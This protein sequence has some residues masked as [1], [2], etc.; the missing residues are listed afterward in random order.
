MTNRID[1]VPAEAENQMSS[2]DRLRRIPRAERRGPSW[3]NSAAPRA[4]QKIAATALL[5]TL[6]GYL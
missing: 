1:H 2:P 6:L 3:I 5:S 4:A